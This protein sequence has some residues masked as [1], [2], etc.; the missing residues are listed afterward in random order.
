MNK[1][2]VC[3]RGKPLFANAAFMYYD[4]EYAKKKDGRRQY[5]KFN[6]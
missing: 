3:K 6:I 4:K 1:S 5:E 2:S